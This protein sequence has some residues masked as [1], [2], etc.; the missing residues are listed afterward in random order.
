[1]NLLIGIAHVDNYSEDIKIKTISTSERILQSSN[2]IPGIGNSYNNKLLNTYKSLR[3]I[4]NLSESDL[5]PIIKNNKSNILY[6]YYHDP[7]KINN[8]NN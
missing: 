8:N 1:M 6:K 4:S 3:N 7:I 2:T 5:C